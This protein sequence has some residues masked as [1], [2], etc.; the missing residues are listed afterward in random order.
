MNIKKGDKVQITKGPFKG[1]IGFCRAINKDGV[2]CIS[3]VMADD[4]DD[5]DRWLWCKPETLGL[6]PLVSEHE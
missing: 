6:Q 5:C 2:C 4:L 1:R 3:D